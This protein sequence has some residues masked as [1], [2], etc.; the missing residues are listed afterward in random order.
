MKRGFLPD[1][2]RPGRNEPHLAAIVVSEP[3]M[4][5]FDA[6]RRTVVVGRWKVEAE[7]EAGGR[8]NVG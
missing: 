5:V 3:A 1:R 4:Q 7:E 2:R 6:I 8:T